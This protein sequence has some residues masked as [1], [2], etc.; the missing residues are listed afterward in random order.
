MKSKL[1]Q[2]IAARIQERRD[3]RLDRRHRRALIQEDRRQKREI[4]RIRAHISKNPPKI[5]SLKYNISVEPPKISKSARKQIGLGRKFELVEKERKRIQD[6][7]VVSLTL[8]WK[9]PKKPRY[10]FRFDIADYMD[11]VPPLPLKQCPEVGII[12]RT[13]PMVDMHKELEFLR[14]IEESPETRAERQK[15]LDLIFQD[16][17]GE[18]KRMEARSALWPY[19]VQPI[20]LNTMQFQ[21]NNTPD[22]YVVEAFTQGPDFPG[23][24]WQPLR[25]FGDREGDA[26]CFRDF[27]CPNLTD[28]QLRALIRAYN[29]ETKYIRVNGRNFIKQR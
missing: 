2:K 1:F 15:L 5:S 9:S 29:P 3:A 21:I 10:S 24:Y 28:T 27:D 25:N 4:D 18:M 14:I 11:G 23:D 7:A 13:E 20:K 6:G 22:G 26:K 19:C 16:V 12:P 8:H 17:A